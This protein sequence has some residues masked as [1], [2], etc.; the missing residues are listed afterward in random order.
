M[1]LYGFGVSLNLW[2][3]VLSS[4]GIVYGSNQ[5]A[6]FEGYDNIFAIA[7]VFLNGLIGV[8]MTFLYKYVFT[9]IPTTLTPT[10]TPTRTLSGTATQ[11]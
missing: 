5:A 2:A 9:L 10:L 6:F 11:S 3:F 8:V 1:V 4:A 7:V